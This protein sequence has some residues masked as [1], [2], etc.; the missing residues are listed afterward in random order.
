MSKYDTSLIRLVIYNLSN[1]H[2][3]D[4]E[5]TLE[6][7][8]NSKVCK[9]ISDEKTGVFTFAPRE[10]IELFEQEINNTN[11]ECYTLK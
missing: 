10:I 9:A 2:K 1:K 7:F 8:Y 3:W 4:Y 11:P 5:Y 6:K